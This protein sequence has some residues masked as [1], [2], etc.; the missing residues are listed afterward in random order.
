MWGFNIYHKNSISAFHASDHI[1]IRFV[2]LGLP[3]INFTQSVYNVN[4]DKRAII[5]IS[6]TQ[7]EVIAPVT[8]RYVTF[9][10]LVSHSG[11]FRFD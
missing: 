10:S 8:V 3:V 1:M 6:V 5:G 2:L 9:F 7:N 4:E 11:S